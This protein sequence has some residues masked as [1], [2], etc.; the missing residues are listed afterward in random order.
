[1]PV[2][3]YRTSTEVVRVYGMCPRDVERFVLA[4][5]SQTQHLHYR[6][7]FRD[8][9]GLLPYAEVDFTEAP[10]LRAELPA[11]GSVY[12]HPDVILLIRRAG[13]QQEHLPPHKEES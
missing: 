10:A 13:I 3:F 1:M 11:V 5:Q 7:Q 8:P 6:G 2:A 12:G 4:L 9:T